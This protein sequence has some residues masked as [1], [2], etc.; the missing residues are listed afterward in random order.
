MTSVRPSAL[1]SASTVRRL[2]L[3]GSSKL[4]V[5]RLESRWPAPSITPRPTRWKTTRLVGRSTTPSSAALSPGRRSEVTSRTGGISKRT[6]GPT[7]SLSPWRSVNHART[8]AGSS[9]T[10]P[11]M[12]VVP[13]PS[14]SSSTIATMRAPPAL[15]SVG[16]PTVSL[17]S[18][19]MEILPSTMLTSSLLAS[20]SRFVTA[21]ASRLDPRLRTVC[22]RVTLKVP[23]SVCRTKTIPGGLLPA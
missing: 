13:L 12:S 19:Q 4:H 9:G 23:G 14:K 8:G 1:T 7:K 21:S 22:L 11:T 6:C 15:S 10:T 3:A 17:S 16:A 18:G 5:T 20:P 2:R